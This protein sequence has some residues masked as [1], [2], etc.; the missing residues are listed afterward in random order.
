MSAPATRY[1]KSDEVSIAYQVVGDALSI[2]PSCWDS[3]LT[4]T[5]SG[6]RR[7][8]RGSSSGWPRPRLM[9]FDKRGTGLSIP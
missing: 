1:A 6:K 5:C 7:Q 8:W 9:L 3:Q 2:W 4:S